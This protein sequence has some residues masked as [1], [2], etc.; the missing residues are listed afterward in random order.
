VAGVVFLVMQFQGPP[1]IGAEEEAFK[2]VDALFTAVTSKDEK[3]LGEC[4]ARLH[5]L[6][7]AAKLAER[8]CGFLDGVIAEARG[9]GWEGAAER[10][11]EFM[12]GQ[13]RG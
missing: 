4:E 5:G 2:A 1:Q 3:R 6:R 13:R 11:Y 8:P 10:L 7:D 9:G 12:L